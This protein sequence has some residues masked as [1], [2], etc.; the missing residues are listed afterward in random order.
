MVCV[1]W[2]VIDGVGLCAAPEQLR[3]SPAEGEQAGQA[4]GAEAGAAQPGLWSAQS[5][6]LR[7]DHFTVRLRVSRCI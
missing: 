5:L 1:R 2:C 7:G 4:G 6:W 3:A